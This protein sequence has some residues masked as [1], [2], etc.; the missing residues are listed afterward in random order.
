MENHSSFMPLCM[1]NTAGKLLQRILLQRL[2]DYLVSAGGLSPNQFS[3]RRGRST[4]DDIGKV[5]DT[6]KWVCRGNAQYQVHSTLITLD[7]RNAFN[8]APWK[9]LDAALRARGVP[10][11][12][13]SILRSYMSDRV[14][15][16]RSPGGSVVNRQISGGIPQSSVLGPTMWN[17]FYHDFLN[18]VTPPGVQLIGFADDLAIVTMARTTESLE[19]MIN[20]TLAAVDQW[21][22]SHGL[23]L[24]HHKTEAVMLSRKRNYRIPG[25]TI[26]GVPIQLSK[27]VRYL[28]VVLDSHLTITRHMVKASTKA[29][30]AAKAL[31]RLMPNIG[32]LTHKK[33]TSHVNG[34]Q[35]TVLHSSNLGHQSN[36]V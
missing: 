21:I 3:F 4:D 11:Y 6:A 14:L 24:A 32:G 7:V 2:N 30:E 25:L 18:L 36:Q 5:L 8:S 16:V 1:L 9:H 34:K 12:L 31:S 22:I 20:P 13:I 33:R 15:I 26:G 27:S 29:S 17:V 28:G 19:N 10:K 23:Q 35:Y